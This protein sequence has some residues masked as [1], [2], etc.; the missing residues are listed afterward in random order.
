[1]ETGSFFLA[2]GMMNTPPSAHSWIV[3]CWSEPCMDV[4]IPMGHGWR[5]DHP[6]SG[7]LLV[8]PGILDDKGSWMDVHWRTE[9][10]EL[11]N[12][13]YPLHVVFG[14]E[15]MGSGVP[16]DFSPHQDGS[17]LGCLTHNI[18]H[19]TWVTHLWRIGYLDHEFTTLEPRVLRWFK[20]LGQEPSSQGDLTLDDGSILNH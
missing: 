3:E 14:A 18:H 20:A 11:I 4:D 16:K 6:P 15:P 1:M 7:F 8:P 19:L 2:H 13:A 12:L 10:G 9:M 5:L 17:P